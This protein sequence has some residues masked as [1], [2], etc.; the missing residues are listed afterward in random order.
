MQS[1]F[2]FTGICY[3]DVTHFEHAVLY[4]ESKKSGAKI[5]WSNL[6]QKEWTAKNRSHSQAGS[7]VV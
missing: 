5:G 7:T 6:R 1:A 2:T 4:R 3:P